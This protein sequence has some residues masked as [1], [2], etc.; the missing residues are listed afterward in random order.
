[1]LSAFDGFAHGE[2]S[3][4]DLKRTVRRSRSKRLVDLI[5]SGAGLLF[6]APAFLVIAVAL[7]LVDGRPIIY[8]H[9]RIGRDGRP[10]ECLKFR[11]MRKDADRRLAELLER[12][13]QRKQE[14]L[15][16][17]KLMNDPRVH[18]LGKYLRM[19]SADELPQLLNVQRGEMSLV[20]PRP[21]V[22]SELE[23]YGAHLHCYLALQPGITGLWQVNRRAETTYEERVQFDVDYY[24]SRSLRIDLA[25][26]IRTVGVVLLARNEKE[27]LTK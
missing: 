19:S 17:Q 3:L 23:R 1:M 26:L 5:L 12:D 20:G 14:W 15:S 13:A 2:Q 25:I 6:L 24:H 11:T 4:R 21:V 9:T 16:T 10:F 27:R 22:A 7:L 18:W 8:R